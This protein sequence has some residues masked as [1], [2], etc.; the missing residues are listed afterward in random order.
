MYY[1][2]I[3]NN[4]I[5]VNKLCT[6]NILIQNEWYT[7][8]YYNSSKQIDV[9]NNELQMQEIPNTPNVYVNISGMLGLA[10]PNIGF[11]TTERCFYFH[12]S[13][14]KLQTFTENYIQPVPDGIYQLV[15]YQREDNNNFYRTEDL[16]L[17]IPG[18]FK[19]GLWQDNNSI[20]SAFIGYSND[21]S[22]ITLFDPIYDD[23]GSFLG[24]IKQIDSYLNS[25]TNEVILF[26]DSNLYIY[27]VTGYESDADYDNYKTWVNRLDAESMVIYQD[28]ADENENLVRT[29][30]IDL[31]NKTAF[32]TDKNQL[33]DLFMNYVIIKGKYQ[34]HSGYI[35]P[36]VDQRNRFKSINHLINNN[37]YTVTAIE[38]N[39]FRIEL[40]INEM[41]FRIFPN[42]IK[43]FPIQELNKSFFTNNK[44]IVTTS[45]I[46][47]KQKVNKK[48]KANYLD[49]V[50]L[51]FPNLQTNVQSDSANKI[52]NNFIF[53]KI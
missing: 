51:C 5:I 43:N 33:D 36:I 40:N 18:K 46:L 7:K 24:V 16:E 26:K 44:N 17:D 8:I 37:I 50:Y 42:R 15:Y 21:P 41:L 38:P 13:D 4:S 48:F 32:S 34:G 52:G 20:V 27:Y 3:E 30:V 49:Y 47:Y 2:D 45:G 29:R 10:E 19:D 14:S 12:T 1:I 28:I 23:N 31:V 22:Q 11:Q 35:T 9:F 25:V 6:Q 53:A 39:N